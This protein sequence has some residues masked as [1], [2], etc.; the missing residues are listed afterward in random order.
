MVQE[1][2]FIIRHPVTIHNFS[3]GPIPQVQA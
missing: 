2:L 3:V 1:Q